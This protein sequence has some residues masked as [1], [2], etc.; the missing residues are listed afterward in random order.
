MD[1]AISRKR[2]L[3]D[4]PPMNTREFKSFTAG[5]SVSDYLLLLW[6]NTALLF[7]LLPRDVVHLLRNF[8]QTRT[9]AAVAAELREREMFTMVLDFHVTLAAIDMQTNTF[10]FVATMLSKVLFYTDTGMLIKEFAAGQFNYPLSCVVDSIGRL[11]IADCYGIKVFRPEDETLV[12]TMARGTPC[13]KRG[14]ELSTD[15]TVLYVHSEKIISAFSTETGAHIRKID[16]VK[17]EPC[18]AVS[19]STGE[20]AVVSANAGDFYGFCMIGAGGE[21]LE[22]TRSKVN[23]YIQ[24]CLVAVDANDAI[25]MLGKAFHSEYDGPGGVWYEFALFVFTR[26]SGEWKFRV[27]RVPQAM[28]KY[29]EHEYEHAIDAFLID[30]FGRLVFFDEHRNVMMLEGK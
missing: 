18:G 22:Y 16:L 5:L 3:S 26:V 11:Y 25:Y 28:R 14:L 4:Q 8:V 6:A 17:Y 9:R 29:M 10:I 24:D 30:K 12:C 7:S 2:A 19:L 20:L 15:E 13:R 21:F 23:G 1:N 27:I